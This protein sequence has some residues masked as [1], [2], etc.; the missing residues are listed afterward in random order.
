MRKKIALN[1]FYTLGLILSFL[2]IIW[3]FQ[4]AQ[5]LL[6]VILLAVGI[7]FGYLKVQLSKEVRAHFNQKDR[8]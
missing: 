5:Y 6:L 4:N 2:G 1:I 7:F 3:S 8:P